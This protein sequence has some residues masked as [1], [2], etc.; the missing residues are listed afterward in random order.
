MLKSIRKLEEIASSLLIHLV[1]RM[2]PVKETQLNFLV[3]LDKIKN[4]SVTR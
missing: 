3:N 4:S 2:N 1:S